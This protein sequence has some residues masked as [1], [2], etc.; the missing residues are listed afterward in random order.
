MKKRI[1]FYT[2]QE[3]DSSSNLY[4]YDA[5]LYDP[6][7]GRFISPDSYVQAPYY[8]QSLSRYSYCRNNP[9]I[10]TDPSGHFALP[11]YWDWSWI[12]GGSN[13]EKE[14]KAKSISEKAYD[15]YQDFFNPQ[16]PD[17]FKDWTKEEQWNY[18]ENV[19]IKKSTRPIT[20]AAELGAG[21][22]AVG[23]KSTTSLLGRLKN[24]FKSLF[25]GK[26]ARNLFKNGVDFE[27]TIV[28]SKGPVDVVAETV[29]NGNTLHLKDIAIYGRDSKP[30]TGLYKE[31]LKNKTGLINDAKEAGFKQLRISGER[32][33]N[34][35]SANPG[36]IVDLTIDL[37]K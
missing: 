13:A 32:L 6:V 23:K 3:L 29:I 19:Q 14:E 16:L 27:R 15:K 10:Y 18:I 33:P 7:I 17:D 37:T 2:D 25:K 11:W 31:V 4:N 36:K 21:G 22:S 28:T 35:S 12:F 1:E 8:P 24:G 30:L 20:L 9:L 5:R 34:S 26:G